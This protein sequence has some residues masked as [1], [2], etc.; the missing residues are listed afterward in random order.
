MKAAISAPGYT[1]QHSRRATRP[2]TS[3]YHVRPAVPARPDSS[4]LTA[5]RFSTLMSCTNSTKKQEKAPASSSTTAPACTNHATTLFEG[6][7]S[8]ADYA[9]EDDADFY[10]NVPPLPHL[11]DISLAAAS[12]ARHHGLPQK[13]PATTSAIHAGHCPPSMN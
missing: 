2:S 7:K 4:S 8:W 10:A 1:I 5:N 13:I 3:S 12:T 9:E 11:E 6:S